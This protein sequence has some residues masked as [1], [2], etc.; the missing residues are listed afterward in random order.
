MGFD[1]LSRGSRG[2][3]RV[4]RFFLRRGVN[5]QPRRFVWTACVYW[6]DLNRGLR[7]AIYCRGTSTLGRMIL[8]FLDLLRGLK[9]VHSKALVWFGRGRGRAGRFRWSV[10]CREY[11]PLAYFGRIVTF[12]LVVSIVVRLASLLLFLHRNAP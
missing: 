3:W 6:R 11:T 5:Y 4:Q 9:V 12:E 2:A 8:M 1:D 7:K 10:E